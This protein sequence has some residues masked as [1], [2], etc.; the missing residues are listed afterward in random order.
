MQVTQRAAPLNGLFS[1]KATTMDGSFHRLAY[2]LFIT[3]RQ[4]FV[5]LVCSFAGTLQSSPCE[6]FTLTKRLINNKWKT[7]IQANG[8]VGLKML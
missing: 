4:E 1:V 6:L 5:K 8:I 2:L 3:K 7:I